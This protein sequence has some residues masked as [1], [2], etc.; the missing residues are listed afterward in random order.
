MSFG[1]LISLYSSG[2]LIINPKYQRYFRWEISQKTKFIE[3]ILL[4]IPIPPIFI[5]TTSGRKWELVDGLQRVATLLEFV[6]IL[7]DPDDSS[8]TRTRP[9]TVLEATNLLPSLHNKRWE[10]SSEGANDGLT[11]GQQRD[12]KRSR[13]RVEILKKESDP[14]AK[15]ELFQRLNTGGSVL[16][17]QEVRSCVIIM[18]SERFHEW[19]SQ[20]AAFDPFVLTIDQTERAEKR[21]RPLEYVIRWLAFRNH[22]YRNALDVHEYLDA[23]ALQMASNKNFKTNDEELVFKSTFTFLNDALEDAAFKKWD[24]SKFLGPSSLAAYEVIGFGVSLFI[25]EYSELEPARRN[26]LLARRIKSLSDN[27]LFRDNSKAGVRGSTRLS[28]LLPFARTFFKP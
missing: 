21:Q 19:I 20:L 18:I 14:L 25:D 5:Y 2:E 10:E 15:Y 11:E 17:E 1:E 26:D 9:S 7:K 28:N 27:G 6:G 22:P 23:A 8:G 16:S 12:I 24:G 3:S 4:G 13:V